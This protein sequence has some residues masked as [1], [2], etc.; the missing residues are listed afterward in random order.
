MDNNFGMDD[1]FVTD[2]RF[3]MGYHSETDDHFLKDKNFG[4]DDCL[5]DGQSFTDGRSIS[6]VFGLLFAKGI[7]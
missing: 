3:Q 5:D 6:A 2:N 1:C 4:M 7:R